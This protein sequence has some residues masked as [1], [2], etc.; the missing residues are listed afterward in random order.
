M[1]YKSYQSTK[2]SFE[3]ALS[4]CNREEPPATLPTHN[5]Y[6]NFSKMKQT[7]IGMQSQSQ[8][9]DFSNGKRKGKNVVISKKEDY[10][11][12]I[13]DPDMSSQ[14]CVFYQGIGYGRRLSHDSYNTL[15]EDDFTIRPCNSDQHFSCV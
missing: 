12:P 4:E 15:V 7:W 8:W 9:I 11:W 6:K 13:N 5:T 10:I 14:A 3:A 2:M 1:P